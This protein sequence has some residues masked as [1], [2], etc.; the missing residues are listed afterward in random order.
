MH[1]KSEQW[2]GS[3]PTGDQRARPTGAL[4]HLH[5]LYEDGQGGRIVGRRREKIKGE[6]GPTFCLL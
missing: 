2:E 4:H 5:G 6:L 1:E 3:D